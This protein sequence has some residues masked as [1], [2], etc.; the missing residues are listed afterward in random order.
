MIHFLYQQ[1]T[2]SGCFF[3]GIDQNDPDWQAFDTQKQMEAVEVRWWYDDEVCDGKLI[4]RTLVVR[5][6]RL[7]PIEFSA[8]ISENGSIEIIK[9]RVSANGKEK[10]WY[11]HGMFKVKYGTDYYE[12]LPSNNK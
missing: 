4:G 3:N 10:A 2:E 1:E 12:D 9:Q 6:Y 5:N 8:E 7:N 11:S